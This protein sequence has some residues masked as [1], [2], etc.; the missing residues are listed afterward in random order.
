LNNKTPIANYLKIQAKRE[1][2]FTEVASEA[3]VLLSPE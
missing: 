1:I 2:Q 3:E